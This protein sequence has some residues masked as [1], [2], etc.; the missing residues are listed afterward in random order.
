MPLRLNL[1]SLLSW[2]ILLAAIAVL[3]RPL[4]PVIWDD[5][6]AFVESALRTLEMRSPKLITE[7]GA[8]SD[9][10]LGHEGGSCLEVQNGAIVVDAVNIAKLLHDPKPVR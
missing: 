8:N 2:A 7:F 4:T 3:L 10:R 5:T 6:P 1:V 9:L